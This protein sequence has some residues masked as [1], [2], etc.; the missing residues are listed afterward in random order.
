MPLRAR[1]IS[2]SA[3]SWG[4]SQAYRG[5]GAHS[6]LFAAGLRRRTI[7]VVYVGLIARSFSAVSARIATRSAS[8]NPGVVRTWS[9]AVLVQGNGKSVPKTLVGE[10]Y[11]HFE[12]PETLGNL[13]GLLGRA[14]L[15][16][17]GR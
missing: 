10:N 3:T 2:T 4:I 17:M 6:R 7:F 11:N 8:L 13:Y 16:L 15:E 14:A 5:E 1:A 9:T 12:L